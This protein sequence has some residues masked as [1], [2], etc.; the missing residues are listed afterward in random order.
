MRETVVPG[1]TEGDY[2]LIIDRDSEDFQ[3]QIIED[4]IENVNDLRDLNFPDRNISSP[5]PEREICMGD[6]NR[7]NSPVPITEDDLENISS[8]YQTKRTDQKLQS[9]PKISTKTVSN[10]GKNLANIYYDE[11]I[12]NLDFANTYYDQIIQN[13]NLTS[14]K[15]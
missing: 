13:V 5:S 2:R 7:S 12:Q 15:N 6:P 14:S 10:S 1:E 3:L 8:R 11:M 9:H 4:S